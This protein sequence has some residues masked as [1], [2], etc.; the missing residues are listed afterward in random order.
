MKILIS[1]ET[2]LIP[3]NEV[4]AQ[5]WGVDKIMGWGNDLKEDLSQLPKSD[6][7]ITFLV[8]TVI[9]E[10]NVLSYAGADLALRIL[11]HY[12]SNYNRLV[13]I[14]LLGFES[15][16][17]F[18]FHYSYPNILKIPAFSYCLFNK[19]AVKGH[20]YDSK[21]ITNIAEYL[22]FIQNLGLSLPSSFKSTH[23]LTNEWSLYKWN[24][25]MEFKTGLDSQN[26]NSLYFD[27]IKALERIYNVKNK[28]LS[29]NINLINGIESLRNKE[30][31]ILIVDDN[32]NWHYFFN[33][34]LS[35][36]TI[37][38]DFIGNDFKKRS[39]KEVLNQ[40]QEKIKT[41]EPDVILL[42]FRLIE[43]KDANSGFNEISG[44]QALRLLKGSF[45]KPGESYGRQ[46]IIFTASSR[47]ENILRLKQCNADGFILKEKA[48]YYASKEITKDSISKMVKSISQAIDRA[49]FLIPLNRH[50]ARISELSSCTKIEKNLELKTSID[51]VVD[52]IRLITQNNILNESIL[53]LVYLNLFLILEKIKGK[54]KSEDLTPYIENLSS[55]IGLKSDSIILWKKELS[56]LRNALAHDHNLRLFPKKE[57]IIIPITTKLLLDR[58]LKLS[59]F[60]T[61]FI[62]LFINYDNE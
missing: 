20:N 45:D 17:S 42:D 53:K 41:F 62:E 61:E 35:D 31:K 33:N 8:P 5:E 46:I 25:Y 3:A 21:T 43:D 40:V 7:S 9:D 28:R 39:V 32:P 10:R 44:T 38:F 54:A 1:F 56:P 51:M 34:L 27:Y 48:E 49:K 11:F 60:I 29:N 52:S 36:G 58:T 26:H 13:N 57:E 37:Q 55:Q 14:I 6:Y 18:M 19:Y 12:I 24:S 30:T 59:L 15:P 4:K 16:R 23:S 47:I 2:D 50:L 22:P